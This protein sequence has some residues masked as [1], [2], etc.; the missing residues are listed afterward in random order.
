LDCPEYGRVQINVL[1]FLAHALDKSS[2]VELYDFLAQGVDNL[3]QEGILVL[4]KFHVFKKRPTDDDVLNFL[5]LIDN[6]ILF[7]NESNAIV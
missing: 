2:S 3:G 5:N 4:R 1:G 7:E 6:S